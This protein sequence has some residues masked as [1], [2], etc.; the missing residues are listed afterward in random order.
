MQIIQKRKAPYK[1]RMYERS[2]FYFL[3]FST[4]KEHCDEGIHILH[5]TQPS[6]FL[7]TLK[8]LASL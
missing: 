1:T 4:F 6:E 7:F 8:I 3:Y 2:L 5:A